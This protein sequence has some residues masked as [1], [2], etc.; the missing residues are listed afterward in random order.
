MKRRTFMTFMAP[1]D[2]TQGGGSGGD[3]AATAGWLQSAF[4]D[5]HQTPAETEATPA[6]TQTQQYAPQQTTTEPKVAPQT[7]PAVQQQAASPTQTFTPEQLTQMATTA[8]VQAVRQSQPQ[9]QEPVRQ[10]TQAEIDQQFGIPRVTEAHI[11]KIF[12]GGP[13]AVVA[14]ESLLHNAG[15]MGA[16][17]AQHAFR[18]ELGTF[19]DQVSPQLQ[20]AQAVAESQAREMHTKAFFAANPDLTQYNDLCS[21][22]WANLQA[23]GWK[24][25][26]VEEAYSKVAEVARSVIAKLPAGQQT[27]SRQPVAQAQ[28]RPTRQMTTLPSGGSG[29]LGAPTAAPQKT[30]AMA[31]FG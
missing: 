5:P 16:L 22:A 1:D 29:G 8:A 6:T 12:A 19:R 27:P 2:G 3:P 11:Q 25:N 23:Q 7:E 18:Q 4:T 15:K 30:G 14:L 13:E 9:Q 20:A 10:L 24:A 21:M 28:N 26:T 17:L 31:I